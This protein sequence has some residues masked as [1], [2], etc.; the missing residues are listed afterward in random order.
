MEPLR[1]GV[2]GAARISENT[3]FP[4]VEDIGARVVAVA[5]RDRRKAEAYAEANGIERT[6]ADYEALIAD[7]EVEAIYNPLPNGLH[8]PWN[9]AA[10]EAG[11]HLLAEKPFASNLAEAIEVHEAAAA[12]P[13]LVVFNGFHYSYHPVFHRF[14]EIL[15]SGEI[16]DVQYVRVVM[17]VDVP[18]L[19]DIRWSWPLAGGALMDVGCYVIDALDHVAAELGGEARLLD[20]KTGHAEGTDPRVDSWAEMT[21]ALPGGVHGAAEVNLTGPRIFTATAVGSKGSV[22]QSNLSYVHTDDRIFVTT[23][24]GTRVEN[25]GLTSSFTFQMRAFRD[26]IRTGAE[27]HTTTA[28]AVENMRTIDAAYEMAGLPLRPTSAGKG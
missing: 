22:H 17:T 16:G 12:R 13:E 1:I 9:L 24:E 6:V 4:P 8:A 25:L 20:I 15:S 7:P 21:F 26:A 10:I 5:A 18:D 14:K 28:A 11:K 19:N 27:Y 23:A 3:L 2:L